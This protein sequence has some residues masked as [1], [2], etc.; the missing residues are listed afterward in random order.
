MS[1][2]IVFFTD[3]ESVCG[4]FLK[5]WSA[6]T[7]SDRLL[8]LIFEIES[9]FSLLVWIERVPSQGNPADTLSREVV[10]SFGNATKVEVD[11]WEMWNMSAE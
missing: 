9:L 3:S 5:S 7:D 11:P 6:N 8:S 4:A 1:Y 10:T 2:R